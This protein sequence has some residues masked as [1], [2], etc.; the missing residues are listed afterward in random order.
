[1]LL[2][3][4]GDSGMAMKIGHVFCSELGILR[5]LRVIDIP[6]SVVVIICELFDFDKMILRD[7]FM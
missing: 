2:S 4:Y 5:Y 3:A 7:I 6:Y 1:M